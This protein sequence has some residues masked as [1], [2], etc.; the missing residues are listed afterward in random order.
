MSNL[1][2]T[3]KAPIDAKYVVQTAD[4]T[5]TNEQDLS[6]LSTGIMRVA[7]TTGVV[8]SLTDSAGIAANISDETGTGALVFAN[9]PTLVTPEIGVATGT[10][11]D[12]GGTTLLASRQITVDTGGGLDINMGTASGDDFS[13]DTSAFVVEGDTGRVGI[14]TTGPGALLEVYATT[15]G[16]QTNT[17]ISRANTNGTV[18]EGTSIEFWDDSNNVLSE[19]KSSFDG[20]YNTMQLGTY[21]VNPTVTLSNGNLGIGTTGPV[22]GLQVGNVAGTFSALA[23]SSE[24]APGT[25]A[26]GGVSQA[27]IYVQGSGQADFLFD[28]TGAGT[29]QKMFQF[30]ND[31]GVLRFRSLL[32]NGDIQL[33]PILGM[34]SA[35][36]VGIGTT[37]PATK[38]HIDQSSTTAALPVATLD[39][40]DIDEPFIKFIGTVTDGAVTGS[41]VEA[42]D[43]TETLAGFVKVEVQDD[44]NVLT[45]QDYFL[46]IYTL[47]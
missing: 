4:G 47:A 40:A 30:I 20:T 37:S 13:I 28:D 15:A 29:N 46:P 35:G 33:D 7:T 1:N 43:A 22:V 45:D 21:E 34:T 36:N 9:T 26:V 8:T 2:I 39:Q 32:D 31:N 11:L 27:R 19:I 12:L 3:P 6:A 17:I 24:N 25:L 18:G 14:G 23:S 44:G 10:S 16:A 41:L 42:A 38:L 5:L